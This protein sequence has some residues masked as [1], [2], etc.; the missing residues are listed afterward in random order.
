[1]TDF[2]FSELTKLAADLGTVTD[3]AGPLIRTAVEITA[4]NVKDAAKES[5][6]SGAKSWKALPSKISYTL[7]GAG[8]N[9][10]G[11]TLQA[12]IGYDR[13]GAGSLG[14]IREFGSPFV[15]AHNDLANALH[16]NEADFETGMSKAT[17]Q[18]EREA[19][20]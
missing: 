11:S 15:P 13:G 3:K 4:R 10:F 9:Q 7:S 19:G 20:L 14:G 8:S 2:D 12:E 6:S 16:A 18:A 5:V 1:M 17:E